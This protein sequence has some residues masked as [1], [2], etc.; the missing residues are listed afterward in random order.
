[1][2][3]A[4]RLAQVIANLLT[5]AAKYTEPGGA[6]SVS[7]VLDTGEVV[8]SVRDT[9]IG[10][11]AGMLPRIFES[12]VQERQTLDRSRG[13]L[14]LGLAIVRSLVAMHGG[15]VRAASAG[16][17]QG[18]EFTVRLP[19]ISAGAYQGG[20]TAGVEVAR[21]ENVGRVL[22]VDDN[23]D[24]AFLLSEML[25]A[26]GYESRF[27]LDGPSALRLAEDFEP[28]IALVD[29]G[30]PVMDGYEVA[31]RFAEHPALGR[32]HLLAVTGYGQDQ[33]RRRSAAAGFRAHLVKP[34]DLDQ[35]RSALEALDQS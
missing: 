2:G 24:A 34:V 32:T 29:I 26:L 12:F 8:L 15:S 18:S 10:I 30:L 21:G 22:V 33:D 6:V 7:A 13:G 28:T 17:G 11:D 27:V 4:G 5:N 23:E 14:G 1:M 20:E 31:K 16:H 19:H 9:G 35:L 3:D 25:S